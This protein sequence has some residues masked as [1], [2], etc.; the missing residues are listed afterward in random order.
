MRISDINKI[1]ATAAL[2][3]IIA[4][5]GGLTLA[6]TTAISPEHQGIQKIMRLI[7]GININNIDTES[8]E[9]YNEI[10]DWRE[11]LYKSRSSAE[12][13]DAKPANPPK[14][15]LAPPR[16]SQRAF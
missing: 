2:A 10:L 3:G 7:G 13:I 6:Q 15:R 12:A 4:S 16:H 14:N 11:K 8:M 9:S 5:T 1:F